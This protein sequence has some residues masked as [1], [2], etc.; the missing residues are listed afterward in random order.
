MILWERFKKIN[1]SV[2]YRPVVIYVSIRF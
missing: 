1:L 2:I